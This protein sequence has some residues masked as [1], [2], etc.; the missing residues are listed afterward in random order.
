MIHGIPTS[1]Y[2]YYWGWPPSRHPTSALL[3][4][5]SHI[6]LCS[7]HTNVTSFLVRHHE[8]LW[9]GSYNESASD[10]DVNILL[11]QD[12]LMLFIFGHLRHELLTYNFETS[13]KETST[14][15]PR[16]PHQGKQVL[17]GS[18]FDSRRHAQGKV[19]SAT[20]GHSPVSITTSNSSKGRSKK[21]TYC[22]CEQSL[23]NTR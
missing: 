10:V 22:K 7:W 5:W 12:L 8:R 15:P 11:Y 1:G 23:A 21:K 14:G 16:N 6:S 4:V 9:H 13:A 20:Q 18:D 17:H 2:I 19:T 3:P